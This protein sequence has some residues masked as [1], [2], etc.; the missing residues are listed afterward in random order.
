M[1][2][3]SRLPAGSFLFVALMLAIEDQG[4][5]WRRFPFSLQ[6][7]IEEIHP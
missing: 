4:F 7:M 5:T 2:R 3:S 1:A 6:P